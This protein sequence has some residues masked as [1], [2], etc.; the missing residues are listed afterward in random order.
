[1][2]LFFLPLLMLACT[3]ISAQMLDDDVDGLTLKSLSATR[4]E[5]S[6]KAVPS[7]ACQYDITYSVF[8]SHK[9]DFTPDESNRIRQG[10][11][12]TSTI[13]TDTSDSYFHVR[14]VRLP[15]SCAYKPQP[16]YHGTIIIHPFKNDTGGLLV[17]LRTKWRSVNNQSGALSFVV[18]AWYLGSEDPVTYYKR[19]R[20][21]TYSLELLD[22]QGFKIRDI[23]LAFVQLVDSEGKVSGIEANDSATLSNAQYRDF[24]S[25]GDWNLGWTCPT[26]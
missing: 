6:W 4:I 11:K 17:S 5:L 20:G 23:E 3:T 18:K 24:S 8:R 25:G 9:E 2:R 26:D 21:C 13:L 14:A 1:M 12:T 19:S 7:V 10:I 22:A 15:T 16:G